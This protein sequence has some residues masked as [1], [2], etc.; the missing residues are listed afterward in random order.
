MT[1][2]TTDVTVPSQDSVANLV[3]G[4]VIGNKTDTHNGDSLYAISEILLDH[5]HSAAKVY[6]TGAVGETVTAGDASPWTLGAYEEI[7]PASTIGTDFDIHYINVEGVSAAATYELVLYA[8]T[9]EIG[10]IRFA[11]VGIPAADIFSSVPFQCSIQPAD[12]QIQAKVMSSTG[13]T[14]TVTVSL[15]YHTY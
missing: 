9:V 3:W 11:S 10:R 15:Y 6:P 2:L 12:T 5:V 7:I 1:Y 13:N 14:D 8:A 4:D